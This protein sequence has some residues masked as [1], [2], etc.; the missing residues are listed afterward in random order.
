MNSRTARTLNSLALMPLRLDF[1]ETFITFY[2]LNFHKYQWK[3]K[4]QMIWN[5][6]NKGKK[7]TFS[8]RIV[9]QFITYERST[10]HWFFLS[11]CFRCDLLKFMEKK[12]N[13]VSV[14][15]N[16]DKWEYVWC[17]ICS[18]GAFDG[19]QIWLNNWLPLSTK[20]KRRNTRK[21]FTQILNKWTHR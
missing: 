9:L 13:F 19:I 2:V 14:Y 21:T 6:S 17:I 10:F 8:D 18:L 16:S 3:K 20:S 15:L 11:F 4:I 5:S 12:W 7:K 1:A